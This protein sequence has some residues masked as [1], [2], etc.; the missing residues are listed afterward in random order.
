MLDQL[1]RPRVVRAFAVSAPDER[2]PMLTSK[3]IDPQETVSKIVPLIPEPASFGDDLLQSRLEGRISLSASDIVQRIYFLAEESA[4]ERQRV[5][6][7][8]SLLYDAM[9]IQDIQQVKYF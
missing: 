6:L 8:C 3:P 7:F 2:S 9:H 4:F 5:P 1:R